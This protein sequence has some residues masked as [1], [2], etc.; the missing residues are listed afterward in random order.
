[1][2]KIN[3]YSA[4]VVL[5]LFGFTVLLSAISKSKINESKYGILFTPSTKVLVE[6]SESAATTYQLHEGTKAKVT[7]ENDNWYEISFN[8]KKGW[9]QKK[10][11]KKI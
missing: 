4:I 3:F 2:E 8:E 5:V 1:M 11:L 7:D 9:I 10:H 6:P